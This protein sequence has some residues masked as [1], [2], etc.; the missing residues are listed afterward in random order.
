M[1]DALPGAPVTGTTATGTTATGTAATATTGLVRGA[2]AQHHVSSY[3]VLLRQAQDAGL[4]GRRRGSYLRRIVLTFAALAAVIAVMVVL[5]DT[6]YQLLVA[7]ALGLV[8]T[9]IAFLGHDASHRQIFDSQPAN[10]WAARLLTGLFG[11]LSYGWWMNKHT[12]HHGAPNQVDKDPDIASKL[13]AFDPDSA[14]ARTGGFARF[15]AWQGTLFLPLLTLEG[16]NLHVHGVRLLLSR[17]HGVKKVWVER[18]FIGV[19]LTGY[20]VFLFL[21]LPPGMAAAFLGV[22]LGVFGF[23]LGGAFAPNHVGMPIVPRGVRVDFLHRQVLMSR[24]VSGGWFVDLLMG[25]LNHQIEHHLFPNMPRANLRAVRP[26]VRAHCAAHGIAYTETT[27]LG[28]YRVLIVYLN[29][30]GVRAADPF[31]CPLVVQLRS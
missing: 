25:G 28:A 18:A 12:R 5:G 11:G 22:Q 17:G 21:L 7:A 27:L 29:T 3:A 20:L 8:L 16:L 24:N 13:L 1:P 23:C 31:R 26:L 4:M 9:Q 14:R 6:W 19:R 15:T 2:A 10:E 30:V